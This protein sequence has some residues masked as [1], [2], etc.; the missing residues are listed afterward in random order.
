M[1]TRLLNIIDAIYKISNFKDL[2]AHN[3]RTYGSDEFFFETELH[4]LEEIVKK[5]DITILE[6]VD[7][8]YK[9]KGYMSQTISS[10]EQKG[11]ITITKC[12]KDGRKNNYNVTKKGMALHQA[13]L[14]YDGMQAAR[15]ERTLEGHNDEDIR[16]FLDFLNRYHAFQ[17]ENKDAITDHP[18]HR[19]RQ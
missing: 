1:D 14:R 15:L 8:F 11:L 6:L 9:T 5:N 10:L 7:I 4:V 2:Y 3:Q 13:H 17:L 12:P 16:L 19:S 18:L